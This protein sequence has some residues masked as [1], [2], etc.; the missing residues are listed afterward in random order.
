MP[1]M[2]G[3]DFFKNA[4]IKYG[5]VPFVMLTAH[6][7]NKYTTEAVRLGAIDYF[8]KPVDTELLFKQLPVWIEIGRRQKAFFDSNPNAKM[9]V[10][11]RLRNSS[12][13][14]VG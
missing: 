14:S 8:I 11:L 1:K 6:A 5:Y 2:N 3:I 7:E 4:L 9:E 12:F 10:L 13:K